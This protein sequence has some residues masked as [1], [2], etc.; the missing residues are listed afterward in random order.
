ST[1][2]ANHARKPSTYT[3]GSQTTVGHHV[4]TWHDSIAQ[5]T[6]SSLRTVNRVLRLS[7]LTGSAVQ[8]PVESGRPRLLTSQDKKPFLD[9]DKETIPLLPAPGPHRRRNEVELHMMM[10]MIYIQ[11]HCSVLHDGLH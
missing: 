10:S 7:R 9:G 2:T 1:T 6:G 11:K 5:V 3:R 8:R 4:H